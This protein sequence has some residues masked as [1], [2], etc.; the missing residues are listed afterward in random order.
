MIK[1]LASVCPK[2]GVYTQSTEAAMHAMGLQ[3][4]VSRRWLFTWVL[5]I[6]FCLL[7]FHRFYN[8][9]I[10]TGILLLLT[11]GIFTI[12]WIIDMLLIPFGRFKD[13][14]GNYITRKPKTPDD[15]L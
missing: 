9:K 7:G 8:K 11:G 4:G 6:F 13:K 10:G 14:N 1:K 2:C 3:G 12:G 15:K 5:S